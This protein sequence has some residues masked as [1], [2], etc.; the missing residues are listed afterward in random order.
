[1]FRATVRR[2]GFQLRERLYGILTLVAATLYV[3][4][5]VVASHAEGALGLRRGKKILPE[6]AHPSRTRPVRRPP[7]QL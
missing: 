1:M 3:R 4:L 2:P 5:K 7:R 6:E